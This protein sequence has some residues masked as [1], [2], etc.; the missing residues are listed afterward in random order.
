MGSDQAQH[1]TQ[2][3]FLTSTTNDWHEVGILVGNIHQ[4][5]FIDKSGT[6]NRKETVIDTAFVLITKF[7]PDDRKLFQL[8]TEKFF[9][10]VFQS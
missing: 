5:N 10:I 4:F 7:I 8:Q 1:E 2:K 3:V 9:G 6:W